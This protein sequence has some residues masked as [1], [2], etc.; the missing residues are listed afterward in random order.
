MFIINNKHNPILNADRW[1]ILVIIEK[2]QDVTTTT[3]K[4][5]PFGLSP[6]YLACLANDNLILII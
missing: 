2:H 6:L 5:G 4:T 1:M 3:R